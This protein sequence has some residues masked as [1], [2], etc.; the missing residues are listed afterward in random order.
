MTLVAGTGGCSPTSTKL[1][2]G[3]YTVTATYTT[4]AN[5]LTSTSASSTLVV[6]QAGTTLTA[7][8]IVIPASG[9]HTITFSA[10]LTSLVTGAGVAGQHILFTLG[11]QSCTATTATTGLAHCTMSVVSSA[12][13]SYSV[14]Y[15]ATVD[16]LSSGATGSVT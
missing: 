2:A 9:R 13:G 4:S 6:D 14:S 12:P 8:P 16:Y 10:T 3:T 5:F 7:S 15:A 11:A 1:A